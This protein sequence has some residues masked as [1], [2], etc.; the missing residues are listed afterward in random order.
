MQYHTML[1]I[2]Y[3]IAYYCCLTCDGNVTM[4]Y[5]NDV[6]NNGLYIVGYRLYYRLYGLTNNMPRG[7]LGK[8]HHTITTYHHILHT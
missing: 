8:Q 6:M 4:L 5:A 2:I 7:I 1:F 3:A